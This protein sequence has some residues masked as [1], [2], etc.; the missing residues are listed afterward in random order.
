MKTSSGIV[1]CTWKLIIDLRVWA[2][3]HPRPEDEGVWV[4]LLLEEV[5]VDDAHEEHQDL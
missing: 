3:A 2:F 1:L 5:G 4:D